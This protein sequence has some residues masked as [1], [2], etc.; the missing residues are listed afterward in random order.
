MSLVNAPGSGN[1]FGFA[2]RTLKPG[3]F[4]LNTISASGHV[5]GSLVVILV[6]VGHVQSM[7]P[8][9]LSVKSSGFFFSLSS[10]LSEFAKQIHLLKHP[11]QGS[12]GDFE[13]IRTFLEVL[14]PTVRVQQDTSA[15][16]RADSPEPSCALGGVLCHTK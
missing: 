4:N 6:P 14:A 11:P 15:L 1:S 8:V 3:K 16:V 5:G 12:G 9:T 13:L 2:Y 7:L 10:D